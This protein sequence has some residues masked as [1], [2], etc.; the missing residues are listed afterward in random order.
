MVK[1][2]SNIEWKSV[3]NPR[4]EN[5]SKSNILMQVLSL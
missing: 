4:T 2:Q 3:N 1:C 5:I